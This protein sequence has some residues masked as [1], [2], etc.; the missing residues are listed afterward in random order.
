MCFAFQ[1]KVE[2]V[3]VAYGLIV[4]YDNLPNIHNT[5]PD[6]RREEMLSIHRNSASALFVRLE[7]DNFSRFSPDVDEAEYLNVF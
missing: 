2:A 1:V 7:S 4:V 6:L 5:Q 3:S